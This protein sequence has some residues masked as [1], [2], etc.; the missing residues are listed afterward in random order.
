MPRKASGHVK[1]MVMLPAAL[2]KTIKRVAGEKRQ[3]Y[4]AVAEEWL[5]KGLSEHESRKAEK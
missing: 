3:T 4:S 2:V 1:F 5:L